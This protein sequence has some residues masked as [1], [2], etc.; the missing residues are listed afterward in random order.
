MTRHQDREKAMIAV[1]Q[2]QLCNRDIDTYIEDNFKEDEDIYIQQVIHQ[3]VANVARY[4]SYINEVLEGWT[5]DRLGFVEQAILLN[6][7]AEFD[8]KQVEAPIIIDEYI[9]LAKEY[10]EEDSYKLINGVL[11]RI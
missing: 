5:F 9:R 7:C 11:D 8:L 1:Y 6:G 3:S 2:Y 4:K 10:C